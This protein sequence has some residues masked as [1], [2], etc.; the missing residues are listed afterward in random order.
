MQTPKPTQHSS[1][2]SLRNLRKLRFLKSHI[3][4]SFDLVIA[5]CVS[6]VSYIVVVST[7]ADESIVPATLLNIGIISFVSSV[8]LLLIFRLHKEIIR[9]TATTSILKIINIAVLKAICIV[10]LVGG[11]IG[12]SCENAALFAILDLLLTS[13][14]LIS[15]RALMISVYHSILDYYRLKAGNCFICGTSDQTYALTQQ[16]NNSSHSEYKIAGL[17][18][19][20]DSKVGHYICGTKIYSLK[21][22]PE[23]FKAL[24]E[25]KQIKKVIFSSYKRFKSEHNNFVNFCVDNSIQ[26]LVFNNLVDDSNDAEQKQ[27]AKIKPIRINDLLS[28]KEVE[29]AHDAIE[30]EIR[31]KVVMITGA[32]GSIGSEIAR[33]VAQLG[34]KHLILIDSAETPMHHVQLEFVKAYPKTA[35]EYKIGDVRDDKRMGG[36]IEHFC[37]SIIFHAAAY[38]HVPMMEANPRESIRTN[39]GGTINMA[40]HAVRCK[41]KKFIMISTDKAVNPTNIM[42]ATKR[43][44]EMYVQNLK[45]DGCTEFITTRFGNVLGSNGSVI[46]LFEKQ[47]R[48][49]GPVTVTDP[50]ITR[51]FMTIP[52]ACRLVLQAATIGKAGEILVFDMGEP[53]LILDL[54]RRMI[55]LSGYELET[56]IKIIFTGLRPGEKLYEELLTSEESTQATEHSKIRI[57]QSSIHDSENLSRNIDKLIYSAYNCSV[58]NVIIQ[59]KELVPE[60]ISRNNKDY[61]KFDHDKESS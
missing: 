42:G 26:M 34:A 29:V 49:G 23:K 55:R 37:P 9:Y 18:S 44:A 10:A 15:A 30:S 32:A 53:E 59:L 36:L 7:Q 31:E 60:F 41:V 61:E 11:S 56:E 51:Y 58:D 43:L 52:E 27:K 1:R 50:K 38:K 16:F 21:Q 12:D 8:A 6:L 54:A 35:I 40:Q 22:S 39:V 46:P 2:M 25:K 24:F 28:R 5:V 45:G 48:E 19:N 3:I 17:L 4:F 57:A 13:F 47:I 20:N 14:I 33:Q